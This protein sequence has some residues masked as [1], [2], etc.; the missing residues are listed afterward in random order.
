MGTS[1][2]SETDISAVGLPKVKLI[3]Y[4]TV[5]I[6]RGVRVVYGD[7]LENRFRAS[8]RGFES[9]P[10]RQEENITLTITSPIKGEG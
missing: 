8:E 1:I 4:T 10:L 9:H 6:R 2:Y 5:V 7:G 3:P